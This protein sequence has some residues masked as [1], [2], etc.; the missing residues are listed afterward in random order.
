MKVRTVKKCRDCG[1]D[2]KPFK[3]TDILC[4]DCI[5][6][7]AVIDNQRKRDK[8]INEILKPIRKKNLAAK[9]AI[10][11]YSKWL[12]E[13]QTIFNKFI[14][15]RDKNR[16]CISCQKPLISNLTAWKAQYD[17]GHFY[18]VNGY[19]NL[20]FN[21][22]NVHGQCVRCNRDL[23]SN[24]TEYAIHL[25]ERIGVDRLIELQSIRHNTPLKLS[26]PEIKELKS[27]Y[28]KRIKQL[29]A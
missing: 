2:F 6:K 22:D 18:N 20:R 4:V 8:A 13:L 17:A 29:E 15:T 11:K 1:D 5:I 14:R 9:E 3:T 16:V 25:P 12:D 26:I 28:R 27:H 10:K 23:H 7:K 19:P 24:N 21:E